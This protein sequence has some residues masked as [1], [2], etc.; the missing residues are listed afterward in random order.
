MPRISRYK[1]KATSFP[2]STLTVF[3]RPSLPSPT[4]DRLAACRYAAHVAYRHR[5]T[6]RLATMPLAAQ[7]IVFPVVVFV[8]WLLGKYR[9][10]DWPGAPK[11]CL[12]AVESANLI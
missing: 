3:Y 4:P 2:S 7:R 11:S 9:G 12:G 8:G 10:D 1:P 6:Q 5:R